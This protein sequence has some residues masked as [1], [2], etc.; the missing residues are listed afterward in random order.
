MKIFLRIVL[1]ILS[2]SIHVA[3]QNS[4]ATGSNKIKIIPGK[5]YEAGWLHRVFFGRLW[6]ELWT[7]EI[8]ADV[9]D[10]GT[11]A[12]GLTPTKRGGGFQT[13]SLRFKGIDGKEYK[14]RSLNK[15]PKKVL[16]LELQES[17][18]ADIVQD[19][20]ST[21]NPV[22]AFVAAPLISAA[23]VLNA[24]P[25]IVYLPDDE[26]LGAF[27][28]EFGGLLG[29]LEEN[30]ESAA[31]EE[32]GFAAADN[33]ASTYKLFK[34]LEDDND[35]Q[36][37]AR[38]FLKA[39]IV[40]VFLGDWDRHV[41][42]WRWAGYELN[43]KRIW[44]P[45][46]RD[47]DQAF[48]RYEGLIPYIAEQ[49]V[50]QLEGC[51]EDYPKIEDLTWSGRYLDRK[52]LSPLEKPV[53]DSIAQFV[54]S[55]MTNDII[56][57]AV[58]RLP[59]EMYV[60]EGAEL[61]RTL[62]S[63]RDQL[64]DAIEE[65]YHIQAKYVDVRASNKSEYAEINRLDDHRLEV[66]L[67]KRDKNTGEKKDE[68]FF[69]RIFDDDQTR[70]IRIYLFDGDDKAVVNGIVN[71]SILVR[72][73]GGDGKDELID[74]SKVDGY[75]LSCT[76]IPDAE[77]K[78]LFYDEGRK[79]EVTK[80]AST[81]FDDDDYLAP[82]N[83]TLKYE[84]PIRDWGHDYRFAPW[85]G[86]SPDDGAFL[87]GGEILY[88]FGFRANPYVWR[89]QLRGGYATSA[90]KFRFDYV[91]DFY[92]LFDGMHVNLFARASGLEVQNFFGFGNGTSRDKKLFNENYYKVK[93]QQFIF[94]PTIQFPTAG[95]IR[96]FF[97]AKFKVVD[98]QQSDSTFIESSKPYGFNPFSLM[99]L[100]TG[101]QLDTRN[102]PER[103]AAPTGGVLLEID[104]SYFPKVLKNEE[105][106]GKIHAEG[107]AYFSTRVI[108]PM[109]LALR[110]AGEK[111]WG[112]FPFFESAFVGGDFTVRGYEKQRFAG[113]ASFYG[114]AEL[115]L[116]VTKFNL[117]L[118]G[119]IGISFF[120]E[121]GRVWLKGENSSTWHE[122][123]GVG[124][125]FSV[126]EPANTLSIAVAMSN[127]K[128]GVYLTGGFMF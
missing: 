90:Q 98:T 121:S 44:K 6:R 76:P 50:A 116:H 3:A 37:D 23:G 4:P 35:E 112:T 105:Q 27:R 127:E 66:S 61:E 19:L 99:S 54:K 104:G 87:G 46:P 88:E 74:N 128:T 124:L 101:L 15:D 84:P 110:V 32:T 59:P 40:D 72:L 5:Q 111:I 122:S 69:H 64:P 58:R 28:S 17:F 25:I 106:F 1:L 8:E 31:D 57:D 123:A 96:I 81:C 92:K 52:F 109:T 80:G 38:E 113:D 14:F 63:R 55:K 13:K 39:R 115:R 95:P 94:Y 48:C 68:A 26:R 21:A 126:I 62:L 16:P 12:G 43:G 33:I 22:S 100:N 24:A 119:S 20:I 114:N 79:T 47:R 11:F 60:K 91:G 7:T 9:L 78:T 73:I 97:G 103:A 82:A 93:Q 89:Q 30:P 85:Y 118:P 102:S 34:K 29:T 107:R 75:F 41:D 67:Y 83:D 49:S 117:L 70:E 71:S 86:V 125:W 42:Q 18:V 120:G 45:I 10:L 36:V 51:E 2:M 56:H 53:W 108:T 77:T 65:Y